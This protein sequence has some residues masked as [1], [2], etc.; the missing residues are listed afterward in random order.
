MSYIIH[1]FYASYFPNSHSLT[2]NLVYNTDNMLQ[3]E[4][5]MKE[6]ELK[7]YEHQNQV[8]IKTIWLICRLQTNFIKLYIRKMGKNQFPIY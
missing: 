4:L 2:F 6:G 7:N 8:L 3:K 5:D 1:I